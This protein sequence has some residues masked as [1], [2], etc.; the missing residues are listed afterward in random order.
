MAMIT[1]KHKGSFKHTESFFERALKAN[2]MS[3]L[4]KYGQEGVQILSAA[5]PER[6]GE[7]ASKWN[8]EIEKTGSTI[9]LAFTNDHENQ[10][11]NV[12]RLIVYGHGLWNGGYVQGNDFVTPAIQPL[13]TNLANEAWREVTK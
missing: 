13:L 6:S 8:Y 1:V 10:G 5:T 12:V 9:T 3:I 2:Y 4:H 7:T 11:V